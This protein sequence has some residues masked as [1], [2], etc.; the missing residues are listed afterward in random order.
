M[1]EPSDNH[2]AP[3]SRSLRLA[4][5]SLAVALL[6]FLWS[7]TA[8]AVVDLDLWH[9]MALAREIMATGKVPWQDHFAFTPTIDLV[10]HHEWGSGMVAYALALAGGG[11]A[12][13]FARYALMLGLAATCW[14][15]ARR[16]GAGVPA[17]ALACCLAIVMSDHAF[18]PIRA[19]MYSYVLTALLLGAFDLDRQGGRRWVYVLLALFPLWVNLH[20]GCLVGASLLGCHW[21]EQVLRG[22]PHRHLMLAGLALI[23]LS[24]VTPWGW[25]Y[26][27]YLVHAILLP[28]PTIAEWS[29]LWVAG[30]TYHV[31]GFGLSVVFL[32]VAL[33]EQ[34]PRSLPGLLIL[35]ATGAAALRSYRFLPF[36]SIAFACYFPFLL[37]RMELGR[38]LER[39]WRKAPAA[40]AA[41]FSLIA[42]GLALRSLS[43]DPFRLQ[44]PGKPIEGTRGQMIYPT[45]AV[46][47]LA[48]NRFAGNVFVPYDWGSYVMWKLGP[49]VKVSFDSRYEVAYPAWRLEEDIALF[50]AREGWPRILEK[51]PADLLLLPRWMKLS[52]KMKELAG[53]KPVYRDARFVLFARDGIGLLPSL[54]DE[55]PPDG[56]F[57]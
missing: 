42:L 40:S 49:A 41:L 19:Q 21:L 18:S 7:R 22:R 33:R 37:S 29:P 2:R 4:A 51:Y 31:A 55:E 52:S 8:I 35:V 5:A 36:Y 26:T 38:D 48:A 43:L 39:W 32:L 46:D 3:T 30:E 28:R 25:H 14:G 34:G 20:G 54:M 16:R 17:T 53:W 45:G 15:V 6:A 56:A 47:Y 44:V 10:V 24:M 11:G 9:E 50:E 27:G 57:P 23:P 1:I 12:I 13:L